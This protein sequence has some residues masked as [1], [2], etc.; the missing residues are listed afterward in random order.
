MFFN[1]LDWE[2]I[3]VFQLS[4]SEMN[5]TS[6]TCLLI[7]EWVHFM[8]LFFWCVVPIFAMQLIKVRTFK[9][10]QLNIPPDHLDTLWHIWCAFSYERFS[11]WIKDICVR[12][13]YSTYANQFCFEMSWNVAFQIQLI[14]WEALCV[15]LPKFWNG[16]PIIAGWVMN[17]GPLKR[18]CKQNLKLLL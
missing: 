3:L 16:I 4:I 2:R 8:S 5:F 13:L 6:I 17:N 11:D 14:Y 18:V 1:E 10:S 15:F 9:D 7:L 12:W